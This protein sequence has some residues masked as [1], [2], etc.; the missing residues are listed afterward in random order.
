VSRF[1]GIDTFLTWIDLIVMK[2]DLLEAQQGI[3]Y[4]INQ[5]N[6]YGN[7]DGPLKR[8]KRTYWHPFGMTCVRISGDRHFF[9]L[10]RSDRDKK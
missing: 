7:P 2:S 9:D 5:Y 6:S 4:G 3:F 10:D 8:L 1:S